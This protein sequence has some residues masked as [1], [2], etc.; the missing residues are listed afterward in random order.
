MRESACRYATAKYFVKRQIAMQRQLLINGRF[1]EQRVTGVQRYA[2]ELLSA[3]DRLVG[4]KSEYTLTVLT[5]RRA[6]ASPEFQNVNC[7]VVGRLSGQWWEQFELPRYVGNGLLVSLGNLGP[8]AMRRQIVTIHDASTAALPANYSWLFRSWYNLALPMLCRRAKRVVTDSM[9][10]KVEIGR[11]FRAKPANVRVVPLGLDHIRF[12]PANT[13]VLLEHGLKKNGYILAVSSVSAHKN[14]SAL[15]EA[16]RCIPEPRP[17]LV[18]VGGANE[19]IFAGASVAV[20]QDIKRLGYV[21]DAQLRALY[22]NALCLVYP[23]LYEGFG[24]PPGEAMACGCPVIVSDIPALREVCGDAALYC[25]PADLADIAD[26]ISRVVRDSALRESLA[27]RGSVRAA[28][29]TWRH[30]AEGLL[31][32]IDEA[33]NE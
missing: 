8:L 20:G 33:M 28:Q 17:L 25:N 23:S 15:V 7:R 18:L 29:F 3:L 11:Y 5:T 21:G 4:P 22:E 13:K 6:S 31:R 19:R 2:R 12:R 30:C 27:A 26:K 16:M 10:S 32:V 24:L 1:L 9:F 14:I